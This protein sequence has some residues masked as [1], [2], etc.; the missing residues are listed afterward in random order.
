MSLSEDLAN[1]WLE[2]KNEAKIVA[3]AEEREYF[4]DLVGRTI[5]LLL[6]YDRPVDRDLESD[7][8]FRS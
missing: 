2:I 8:K 7:D 5:D 1:E 4:L 3:V 6:M